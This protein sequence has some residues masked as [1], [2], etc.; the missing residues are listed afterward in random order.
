[1]GGEIRPPH[2]A[3]ARIGHTEQNT[4]PE[5]GKTR[6]LSHWKF[7]KGLK[8]PVMQIWNLNSWI[9]LSQK[10]VVMA[11][12]QSLKMDYW[13]VEGAAEGGGVTA[14]QVPLVCH[15]WNQKDS[16]Q[17]RSHQT[18]VMNSIFLLV[19]ARKILYGGITNLKRMPFKWS[20][21]RKNKCLL[22]EM[23]LILHGCTWNKKQKKFIG[24]QLFLASFIITI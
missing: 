12:Q 20:Q 21:A 6:V 17:S 3:M 18:S 7:T 14:S 9:S 19:L 16:P 4:L 15:T 2:W 23:E 5:K 13:Q 11:F 24:P 22:N 8:C 1:M 10:L